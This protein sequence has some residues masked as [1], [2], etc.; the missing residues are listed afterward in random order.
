MED[1]ASVFGKA[2]NKCDFVLL[3]AGS[4]L[5]CVGSAQGTLGQWLGT[6]NVPIK[7]ATDS[8]DSICSR[9]I[10]KQNHL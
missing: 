10:S 4:D 6:M 8:I 5:S 9:C 7:G 1:L 2:G 3:E